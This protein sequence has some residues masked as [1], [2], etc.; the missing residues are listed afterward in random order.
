MILASF[1]LLALLSSAWICRLTIRLAERHDLGRDETHG[2]QKNHVHAVPRL[3]GVPVFVAVVAGLLALS[4]ATELYVVETVFLVICLLP[5]FGIGLVE[6][7]TRSAGVLTRLVF[8]MIAAAMAWWL[9]GASLNRLDVGWADQL[10]AVHWTG[11]FVLTLIAA[12][13]VSHAVNIIDGCNGLIGFFCTVV[14]LA[15][16]A[17]AWIVGDPFV[18]RVSLI[19]ATSI[20]GFLVWNFPYGRI[21]MGDS[22]AYLVGFLIATLSILLVVRNPDVSPWFPMLLMIY[23]VWETLFSMYRR[24]VI[25][26]TSM[27]RADALHLHQLIYRRIMRGGSVP[28]DAGV[29]VLQNS[30]TSIYLWILSL[31]CAVFAVA[32]WDNT[33]VLIGGCLAVI[34]LYMA[35]YRRLVRFRTPRMLIQGPLRHRR[36]RRRPAPIVTSE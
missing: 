29:I 5:A 2:V 30:F 24:A 22:G 18:F 16:A 34:G 10:L 33:P 17:V 11:P 28:E 31:M 21:F 13:G 35:F 15:I 23:P 7:V 3:G 20:A 36:R 6:D 32:M 12:A 27:G 1:C 9:L 26:R 4:R 25:S 8:T 19:V 14:M